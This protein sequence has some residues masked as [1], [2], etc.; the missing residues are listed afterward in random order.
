MKETHKNFELS[1]IVADETL[2]S[3]LNA[4][5]SVGIK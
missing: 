5:F 2:G 1:T 3:G 4:S